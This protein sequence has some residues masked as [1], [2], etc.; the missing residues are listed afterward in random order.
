MNCVFCGSADV[1]LDKTVDIPPSKY[2]KYTMTI[3]LY[4]CRTCGRK[5]RK[6]VKETFIQ[7][8]EEEL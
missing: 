3:N 6:G 8:F 4:K 5:F 1:R 7:L 2:R